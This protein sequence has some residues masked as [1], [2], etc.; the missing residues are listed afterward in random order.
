[1]ESTS[2]SLSPSTPAVLQSRLIRILTEEPC[3][4]RILKEVAANTTK[5]LNASACAVFTIDADG[6]RATQRAGTG[7]QEQHNG[8]NDVRV[9]AAEDVPEQPDS[10]ER[11][12]LTGWCLSTGKPFLASSA[13][14]VTEHTH[15]L[16]RQG[17]DLL[18]HAFLA[19]PIRGMDGEVV[20]VIKAE[21]QLGD[22]D[23]PGHPF[24]IADELALETVAR[25]A[26][27]C[28]H[29]VDLA[30]A[31]KSS[32][33]ITAWARD[34]I[35]DASAT[36]GELDS[37]LGTVV[38]VT[39]A[40][41]GADSCGIFLRDESG[42]TL[43][44]RAGTGSQ[45]LREVIRSYP[46]PEEGSVQECRNIAQCNPPSCNPNCGLPFEKRV[47]LTAW[48][49]ATGKSFHAR[50]FTELHAHCH[51]KGEFDKWNFPEG[52]RTECGGF[53][54]FPLQVGGTIIG[55]VK[56]ENTSA[57]D[58]ADS[59]GFSADARQ[60]FE[61]LAQDIA[62]AIMGL[63]I[64]IPGRYRVIQE[65]QRTIL[66]ILRGGLEIKD[67]VKKV[68]TETQA[69]FHA[70]ACAL[71]LKE[72]NQLVQSSWAAS[73]WGTSGPIVRTYDLVP[74]ESIKDNPPPD[75]KVGL[76]VW[77]AVKHQ[78]FTAR[79]NT[80]LTTHPH[81]KGT[82]DRYN[83][84]KGGRCES[85]MGFPLLIQEGGRT[86]LIGVL[87]VESKMKEVGSLREHTYFNEL[88]ELVFGLIANSAAIAIQNARLLEARLEAR[89]EADRAVAEGRGRERAWKEFSQMTAHRIGTEAAIIGSALYLLKR[90]SAGM[91]AIGKLEQ[92]VADITEACERT[93]IMVHEFTEFAK[94]PGLKLEK[95][96]V[97]E[98]CREV[99]GHADGLSD[100]HVHLELGPDIPLLW[101]D[102]EKLLY[103]LKEMFQNAT[104]ALHSKGDLRIITQRVGDGNLIRIEF[105]D[106]G[107]GIAP[108][109][110][111]RIFEPGFRARPGGTGLGLAI[112][113]KTVLEHGGALREIGILGQGAHF[114]I[115][116]PVREPAGASPKQILIVDDTAVLRRQLEDIVRDD[117]PNRRVSSARNEQEAIELLNRQAFDLII[118]DIKLDEAEGTV[119]G[120][121]EV[122][123]AARLKDRSLPVI[124]VTAHARMP[125]VD[126]SLEVTVGDEARRLGSFALIER[127]QPNA[128]DL[129]REAISR[130]LEQRK[131]PEERTSVHAVG[132]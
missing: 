95:L 44:Q 110:K 115:E 121:L 120:G 26:N 72:G 28:I 14:D 93:N 73:G 94:P 114:V 84:E 60:R 71:F 51:H 13:N 131:D 101:G 100:L 81:H 127:T 112:V 75:E 80:E 74:L 118:T 23:V 3:L 87:K 27:R 18:A 98:L 43:T 79:S 130:A 39:A 109:L 5:E 9:I 10:E 6:Q 108:V 16:A 50:N 129:I 128:I 32:R 38:N 123:Q 97:N 55:V 77:I 76:T 42:K 90:D 62:L 25:I 15:Y 65:A 24:S 2:Q 105:M 21:R 56:V 132:G 53:L 59:K 124:V 102:R 88:D 63:Q 46:W 17:H 96:H 83:F 117:G 37:L 36:E 99:A 85:F 8:K 70:G 52:T 107:P 58:T 31:G 22:P 91:P 111:E 4:E 89:R 49:A 47:G 104:K 68:V 126:G 64:Q 35:E 113:Q 41:M 45:A 54:G 86:E 119:T 48:I 67:L 30:R 78:K 1:M 66:E 125:S 116:F 29:Y 92:H 12:G 122:L 61:L 82:Y 34:V 33:A 11:L 106:S 69:L 20:G 103:S 19:V 57:K 7:Y 40:A